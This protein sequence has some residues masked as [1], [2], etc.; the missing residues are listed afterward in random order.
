MTA[1]LMQE[2]MQEE[3]FHSSQDISWSWLR[4]HRFNSC[5]VAMAAV[6]TLLCTFLLRALL[7][8]RVSAG[9]QCSSCQVS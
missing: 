6:T 2:T 4:A 5:R 3:T 7:T 9:E 1:E 8:G